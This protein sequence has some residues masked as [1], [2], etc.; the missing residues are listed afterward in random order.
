MEL[1]VFLEKKYNK[2]FNVF[3]EKN[4]LEMYIKNKYNE[5]NNKV[6]SFLDLSKK[7]FYKIKS[8]INNIK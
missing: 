2:L 7:D 5:D 8:F 4:N 6:I 3:L 1:K